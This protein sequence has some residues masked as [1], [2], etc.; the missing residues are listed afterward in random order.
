MKTFNCEESIVIVNNV[1][2][3]AESFFYTFYTN[4]S[5]Q[6]ARQFQTTTYTIINNMI[7]N[8]RNWLKH[9]WL[10][11]TSVVPPTKKKDLNFSDQILFFRYLYWK[12]KKLLYWLHRFT[13]IR[14]RIGIEIKRGKTEFSFGKK[15]LLH[16]DI[17]SLN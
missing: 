11:R 14:M 16:M 4:L 8:C 13:A 2:K 6:H 9:W 5:H 1:F 3:S 10:L 7:N 17:Y 12:Q 15:R